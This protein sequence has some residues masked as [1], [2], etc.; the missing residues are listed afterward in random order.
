MTSY[1]IKFNMVT[2]DWGYSKSG[3]VAI[4]SYYR[5]AVPVMRDE[6]SDLIERIN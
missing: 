2:T 4:A 3:A 6:D 1:G 5:G